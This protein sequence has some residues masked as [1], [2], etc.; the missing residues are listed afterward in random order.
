MDR[1]SLHNGADGRLLPFRLGIS[2][3][4]SH[5]EAGEIDRQIPLFAS[6]GFDSFF[7]SCGVTADFHRI[8]AW[9]ELAAR[10]GIEFEA[11]HAPTDGV[12]ALWLPEATAETAES[13]AYLDRARRIIGYCAEGGVGKLVLHVA[14]GGV[15]P[16]TDAGL[17]R[18]S[19]LEDLA[20]ARG[21]RLCYEN[22]GEA[23]HL[24][25]AVRNA[26][27]GHGFCHDTGHELCY[28]PD[29]DYLAVLGDRILYTHLHDN[30]GAADEHL[31]P[32]DG[33][34]DWTA[35]AASLA[36]IGYCGTLN[37]ELACM[38]RA[39]YRAMSYP[40]FLTL[41]RERLLRLSAAIDRAGREEV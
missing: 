31:L 21:V 23:E 25:A 9:A 11:V 10:S 1:K 27:A 2:V 16:V 35:Y 24:L 22:A 6:L 40:A 4:V 3:M 29:A 28:T 12:N 34:R 17:A 30:H 26:S 5:P 15:H 32:Y 8:P 13:A 14:C 18:F 38:Y 20:S 36:R 7:L 33:D 39:D 37:A 41:A 19:A